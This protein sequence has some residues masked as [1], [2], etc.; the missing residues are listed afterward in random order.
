MVIRAA[1]ATLAAALSAM[2]A[3]ADDK[4]VCEAARGSAS[5][6]AC[7]RI[8]SGG[9][10]SDLRGQVLFRRGLAYARS[11]NHRLALSDFE[12][13]SALRPDDADARN[14][15]ATM[16]LRLGRG[17]EAKAD[18]RSEVARD[19]GNAR[20]DR[21]L[22]AIEALDDYDAQLA[23]RQREVETEMRETRRRSTG[24]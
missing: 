18:L 9:G 16:K 3:W 8:L 19:P 15:A 22:R 21:S 7:S 13:S 20:A 2:P 10:A 11:G 1:A 6:Q 12:R 23:R 14:N 17:E 4:A 24:R 5:V